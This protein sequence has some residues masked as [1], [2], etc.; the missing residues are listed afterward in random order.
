MKKYIILCS[1]LFIVNSATAD[2]I[3]YDTPHPI[4]NQRTG[5]VYINGERY[6]VTETIHPWGSSK[7]EVKNYNNSYRGDIDSFGYGT[8]RDYHGNSIKVSPY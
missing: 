7:M 4:A 8:L 6:N 5:S 1:F 3:R 2:Q